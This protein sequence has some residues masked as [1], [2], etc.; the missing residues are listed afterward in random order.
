[1]VYRALVD[2]N[3]IAAWKVPKGGSFRISLE[4]LAALVEAG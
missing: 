2:P 4:K 3:A 1:M